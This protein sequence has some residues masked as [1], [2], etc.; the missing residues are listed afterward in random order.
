MAIAPI[1]NRY[2]GFTFAGQYSGTYGVY[3]Q[4]PAVFDAPE[5][6]V[7]MI[8]IPGRDG[9]LVLDKGRFH[10]IEVTYHCALPAS[11]GQADF[12]SGVASFR[13]ML[14][15][16]VGYQRLSDDFNTSEYRMGAFVNGLSVNSVN[17]ES[18]TF[19]VVFNCKPQRFLTSGETATAV[20]SGGKVTNPT[21]F[22]ARPQLQ[23]TGY[24]SIDMGGSTITVGNVPLG[25]IQISSGKQSVPVTPEYQ[26][27]NIGDAITVDSADVRFVAQKASGVDSLSDIVVANPTWNTGTG[28]IVNIPQIQ[29]T[30]AVFDLKVGQMSLVYG[31]SGTP[32]SVSVPYF[33][34]GLVGG[35]SK[36]GYYTADIA[37][38]Y[39]GSTF[40][41][42]TI[43]NTLTSGTSMLNGV[44]V[45][46]SYYSMWA[47][48]S[49]NAGGVIYIDLDIG[50]AYTI[51]SDVVVSVNN[52][53]SIPTD[54]PTLPPGDTTFTY[55]GT[56]TQFKVVPRWWTV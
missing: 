21:L 52:A 19:D 16:K 39:D 44:A 32:F 46:T 15:S 56:I 8:A 55:D 13:N 37:G 53:V 9:E 4:E 48:S 10:N 1:P 35:V 50:E 27:V 33:V 41:A 51:Q 2:P 47:D 34:R 38:V 24:G 3:I 25:L 30:K 31:T 11:S 23:V 54:L 18:G 45:V 5:R 42:S 28:S 12:I 49:V 26:F 40:Q 7:E 36:I 20:S 29:G 43:T 17:V 6:D 22:N 14:A